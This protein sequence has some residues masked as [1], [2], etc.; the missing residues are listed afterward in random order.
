VFLSNATG[1]IYRLKVLALNNSYI[2]VGVSGGL[3][4]VYTVEVTLSN[5]AG[6]SIPAINGSNIFEYTLQV[7][8][9]YPKNGSLFGGTLITI[10]GVNFSPVEG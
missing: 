5:S 6:N 10:T 2:K 1:K 4:G 3:P 8:S 9:V 7:V